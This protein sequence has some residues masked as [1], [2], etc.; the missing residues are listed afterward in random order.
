MRSKHVQVCLDCKSDSTRKRLW[1]CAKD[2]GGL[3]N[4]HGTSTIL[5]GKNLLANDSGWGDSDRFLVFTTEANMDILERYTIWHAD[6]LSSLFYQTYTV[7][8]VM[9]ICSLPMFNF[10]SHSNHFSHSIHKK[11]LF[12]F[13]Q[14]NCRKKNKN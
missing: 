8:A 2:G 5:R 3:S 11:V 9:N 12:H 10:C 1:S 7:N 13:A 14:A 6:C 4:S